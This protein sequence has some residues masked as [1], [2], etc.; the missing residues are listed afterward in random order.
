MI[1]P[2]CKE[3]DGGFKVFLWE[4]NDGVVFMDTNENW[5]EH[6]METVGCAAYPDN[7]IECIECG[8]KG[9]HKEFEY[10]GSVEPPPTQPDSWWTFF[11]NLIFNKRGI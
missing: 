11:R 2:K 4:C 10:Q 3:P 1:C 6:R 8:H 7:Y 9:T 5:Q